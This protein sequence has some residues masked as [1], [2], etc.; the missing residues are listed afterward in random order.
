MTRE[1]P[2]ARNSDM[3]DVEWLA[4]LLEHGLLRGCFV[5]NR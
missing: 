3:L 4:A 1:I 5:H 2:P